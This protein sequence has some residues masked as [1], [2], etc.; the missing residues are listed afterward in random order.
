MGPKCN[1]KC[2]YIKNTHTWVKYVEKRRPWE[3]GDREWSEAL[4]SQG[5][6]GATRSQKKWGRFLCFKIL[7]LSHQVYGNL[8]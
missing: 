2:H 8:I 3:E 4:R 1:N 6:L 7:F 5:T